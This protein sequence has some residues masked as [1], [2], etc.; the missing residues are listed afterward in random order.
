MFVEGMSAAWAGHPTDNK[1]QMS[2]ST[3]V[4]RFMVFPLRYFGIKAAMA[5]AKASPTRTKNLPLPR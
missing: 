5:V 2:R 3:E 1:Q 4:R